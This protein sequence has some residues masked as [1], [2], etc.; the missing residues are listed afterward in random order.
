[1]AS[2]LPSHTLADPAPTPHHSDATTRLQGLAEQAAAAF[3]PAQNE[4]YSNE[5]HAEIAKATQ[6]ATQG[7]QLLD[8]MKAREARFREL[9]Q[10]DSAEARLQRS[11]YIETGRD[12]MDAVSAHQAARMRFKDVMSSKAVAQAKVVVG[13]AMT[14]E[15][16]KNRMNQDPN[17]VQ[18]ALEHP[19]MVA[20]ERVTEAY[21]E[22]VSRA[23]DVAALLRS[24]N[25]LKATMD[26]LQAL[27]SE[28]SEMLDRIDVN[29]AQAADR[30]RK[31][32]ENLTKAIKSQ[33]AVRKKYCCIGICGLI[34]IFALLGGIL[35]ILSSS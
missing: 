21:Y 18:S 27:V 15:E 22:A 29:V 11:Q 30:V 24:I 2:A 5:A 4:Q 13:D 7:K 16:L 17:F 19:D 1:M 20:N 12:Y 28:Q 23:E 31:G 35:P 10:L 26:D 9:G 32:N 33:K 25:E 14:E 34:V 3:T 6:A 8:R